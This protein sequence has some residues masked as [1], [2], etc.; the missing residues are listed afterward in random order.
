M[1]VYMCVC[2][3]WG[4]KSKSFR[5]EQFK[6]YIKLNNNN[7][8]NNNKDIIIIDMK[9][10]VRILIPVIT[11]DK[12]WDIRFVLIARKIIYLA[13]KRKKKKKEICEIKK[14]RK[15]EK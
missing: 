4:C 1:C 3:C 14:G 8:N 12:Q 13:S 5:A 10:C 2:V 11:C 15:K 7:N 9:A 6:K